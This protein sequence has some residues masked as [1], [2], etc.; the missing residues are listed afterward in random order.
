MKNFRLNLL[1]RVILFSLTVFLLFYLLLYFDLKTT[2]IILGVLCLYQMYSL[3][4][5]IDET[6]REISSFLLSIK[7]SDFSQ[8]FSN[9]QLGNSF[10]DLNNSF[11][12]VIQKF[13]KTRT[14]K[15][16]HYRYLNTVMQHVG[17]GL[18]SFDEDGHVEFIN[19]SAK[20]LL[21][22]KYLNNMS[23]LERIQKNLS[24]KLIN[25]QPGHRVT[26]K[27]TDDNDTV[28]LIL[29]S[30]EFRMRGKLYKLISF[31]N[32]HIELEEKEMDAWQKLI[33]VLTHEIMNSV[34]PISSLA[35][36][37]ESMVT[38]QFALPTKPTNETVKDIKDALNTIQR[39]SH[40]LIEFVDKYRSLAKIPKPLFQ[41]FSVE[42]L[43]NRVQN[44]M[45]SEIDR[46]NINFSLKI[47]PTT[48][49]LNAD[50]EQIEQVLINLVLNAIQ[51][52]KDI[53]SPLI[54]LLAYYDPYRKVNIIVKD[55]GKG[56]S[57]EVQ[58]KIFI[59]FFT[60]RQDGSGIGLSLSRQII[61]AHGGTIRI[62]SK[63]S[64]YTSIIIIL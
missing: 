44:L 52:V 53:Q 5:Y 62:S 25:L 63:E 2:V 16:E 24:E 45:Q 64:S 40:G 3:V 22:I 57:K 46:H 56:I 55:N 13:Q 21:K 59:P 31:Q 39:R 10:K 49:Q 54:E 60:T 38:E 30:T 28:Q 37:V 48:I 29:H 4:K 6:N 1:F 36:T 58:E 20:R 19:N 61:R 41:K 47:L 8:S 32:I 33:R 51:A 15:E 23:S 17:V 50:P 26:L 14:E 42:E 27:L 18:L 11:N 34:T 7:H 43:F 9:H 35:G 12:E